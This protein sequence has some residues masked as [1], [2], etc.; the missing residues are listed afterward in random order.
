MKIKDYLIAVGTAA[1]AALAIA[2]FIGL[3][4]L[5]GWP[6]VWVALVIVFLPKTYSWVVEYRESNELDYTY[7]LIKK[8][9]RVFKDK[10]KQSEIEW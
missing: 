8:A 5:I 10:P 4:A 1:A 9:E 3:L 7:Y 2:L 6:V